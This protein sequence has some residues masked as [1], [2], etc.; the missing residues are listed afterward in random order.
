MKKRAILFFLSVILLLGTIG[1]ASAAEMRASHNLDGYHVTLVANGGGSMK[2]IVSIDGAGE[3][4]KIGVQQVDIDHKTSPDADWSFYDTLYGSTHP[5]FY[6][7][8]SWSYEGGIFFDGIPGETYRV[9]VTVYAK[10]KNGSDTGY[11]S[12]FAVECK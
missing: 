2:I 8:K 7:Y 6:A 3:Q 9:T 1:N 10:D 12:S 11:V 4:E 5:E